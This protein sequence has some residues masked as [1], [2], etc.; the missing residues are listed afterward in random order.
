MKKILLITSI[1]ILA[2]PTNVFATTGVFDAGYESCY[3]YGVDNPGATI[4]YA[5]TA[6]QL[7]VQVIFDSGYTPNGGEGRFVFTPSASP[8]PVTIDWTNAFDGVSAR[9]WHATDVRYYANSDG[10]SSYD[11]VDFVVQDDPCTDPPP[12][13]TVATSTEIM[14]VQAQQNLY[15]GFI[16]FFISFFG[17]I[18]LFR[19]QR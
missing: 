18:W 2:N 8:D 10:F 11:T 12:S 17:M 14:Q 4:T 9:P 6:S 5:G 13:P 3:Q 1:L 16:V 7:Q 19:K 15:N